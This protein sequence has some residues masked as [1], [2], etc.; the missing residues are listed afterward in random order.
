[1]GLL[2]LSVLVIVAAIVATQTSADAIRGCYLTNWAQYRPSPGTWSF[3][4]YV[5]GTC[6]HIFYAFATTDASG[7]NPAPT[8]AS[9]LTVGYPGLKNLKA[10]QSGLKTILS[11]GGST[12]GDF[13]T[14]AASADT[15]ATFAKNVVA[16]AKQYDF[17]GIDIDWE[18]PTS[19][20]AT[21]FTNLLQGIKTAG[22]SDFIVTAAVTPNIETAAAGYD[23]SSLQSAVDYL[24]IMAYDYNG[25]WDTVTSI[26]APLYGTGIYT[27][28]AT[29]QYYK[30]NFAA[31]QIL[32]GIP[33]YGRGWTLSSSTPNQGV[34]APAP[35][36]SP[37]L[38]TTQSAGIL[39]Y[40]EACQ[41]ISQGGS[42]NWD[43][44]SET[45]YTQLNTDWYN[46]ENPQSVTDKTD[47]AKTNGFAGVFVWTLDYD[48][49]DN[50]CNNGTFPLL[51]SIKNALA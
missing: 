3:D 35:S 18:F 20:Q 39:A 6:T 37:A 28:N 11:F 5:S 2:K 49:L 38:A 44:T 40:Y 25:S 43:S 47:Y 48:D 27:V 33:T 24:N 50:T 30:E 16:F 4:K 12:F 15:I 8:D 36:A 10:Q 1:M 22:G 7:N 9:D 41:V 17:D 23:L 26:N 21:M 46:Y 19:G 14:I 51:T 13:P 32:L 34:G 31:A 29:A 45:P 42:V